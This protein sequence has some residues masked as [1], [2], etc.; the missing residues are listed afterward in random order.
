M[1]KLFLVLF[2]FKYRYSVDYGTHI[3]YDLKDVVLM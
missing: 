2:A 3:A 1:T